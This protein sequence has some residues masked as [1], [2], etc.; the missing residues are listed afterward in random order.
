MLRGLHP[1][2]K[3]LK[4][5]IKAK[6]PPHTFMSARS[7]L[8]LEELSD[9][10]DAKAE[11]NHALVAS[12]GN[13]SSNSTSGT[14]DA[15]S[16]SSGNR[17][18]NKHQKRGRG[19]GGTSSFPNNG[20]IGGRGGG[21]PSG[22]PWAAGYNPWTGLVQAWPMPFRAPGAGILGP[23]P[24]FQPQQAMTA[25]HQPPLSSSTSS[26]DTSALYSALQNAGVATHQPPPGD[27]YLDIGA[28]AHM[29]SNP[30]SSHPGSD[31]PM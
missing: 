12:H 27:W 9:Q 16:G 29:S 20:G 2:Y 10:Q 4:P 28:T 3:H 5:V 26:W 8:V 14:S 21:Q 30:G 31:A 17:N 22:A 7:F 23:R 1:R 13:T 6:F 24:P 19:S 18:K 25:A 15:P 11:A